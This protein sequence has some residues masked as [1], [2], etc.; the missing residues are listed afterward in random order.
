METLGA[1]SLQSSDGTNLERPAVA[2]LDPG[3]PLEGEVLNFYMRHLKLL[4]QNH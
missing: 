4:Q 2:M 3:A 1:D